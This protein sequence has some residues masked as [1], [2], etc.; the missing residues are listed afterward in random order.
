[1]KIEFVENNFSVKIE[2]KTYHIYESYI[3]NGSGYT[4]AIYKSSK[5]CQR[6]TNYYIIGFYYDKIVI[7]GKKY[8]YMLLR[9]SNKF[10][11]NV[12]KYDKIE[13]RCYVDVTSYIILN[14]NVILNFFGSEA[15]FKSEMLICENILRKKKLMKIS[16]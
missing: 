5:I 2:G 12:V 4:F 7:V 16:G 6:H 3:K 1:M 13:L 10:E 15:L 14:D 11:F 8:N 9:D